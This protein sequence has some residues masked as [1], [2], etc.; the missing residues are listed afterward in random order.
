MFLW[1]A[2]CDTDKSVRICSEVEITYVQFKSMDIYRRCISSRASILKMQAL[3]FLPCGFF[4]KFSLCFFSPVL[5]SLTATHPTGFSSHITFCNPPKLDH[6][7]L[8]PGL[9]RIC[10]VLHCIV[11]PF[12]EGRYFALLLQ[13]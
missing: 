13:Y 8:S 2:F 3:F 5:C 1:L 10:T 4:E 9:C 11:V 6:V 12:T 7:Y